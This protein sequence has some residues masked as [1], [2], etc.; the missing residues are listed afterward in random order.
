M[1]DALLSGFSHKRSGYLRRY[2]IDDL[3][4]LEDV[5]GAGWEEQS[6]A[7]NIYTVVPG[8]ESVQ[9]TYH[10]ISRVRHHLPS[11]HVPDCHITVHIWHSV[12]QHST[13]N[14][15]Q[16]CTWEASVRSGAHGTARHGT[17]RTA[18]HGTARHS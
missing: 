11:P 8:P 6:H 3:A 4:D 1:V 7:N 16:Q 9:L 13:A 18:R 14:T 17:A 15:A 2:V 12:A 10:E 5:F